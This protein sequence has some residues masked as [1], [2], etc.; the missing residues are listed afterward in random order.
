MSIAY[1]SPSENESRQPDERIDRR[2]GLSLEEF[3]RD[4]LYPNKP[5]ILMDAI[6]DWAA[7]GKWSPEWLKSRYHSLPVVADEQTYRFGDLISRILTPVAGESAPYLRNQAIHNV[8]PELMVDLQPSPRFFWP[9]W[10]HGSYV[11]EQL[12][13]Y[14]RV[15]TTL[16]LFVGGRGSKFPNLHIDSAHTHAFLNQVYGAKELV[17]Y[18]P[19]QTELVYPNHKGISLVGDVD[20]PDLEQFPLFAEAVPIRVTIRAGDTAFI[21]AGWWHTARMPGPSITVS[22]NTANESNWSALV[23]DIAGQR[24]RLVGL[25]LGAYLTAMGY[26]NRLAGVGRAPKV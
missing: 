18:S 16:E 8:F 2:S 13:D 11:P 25:G 23:R 4:Y 20:N 1:R 19:T 24:S 14:M 17:L 5:V 21:P 10:L 9:N 22:V 3:E 12:G 15:L 7:V 6:E 26:W